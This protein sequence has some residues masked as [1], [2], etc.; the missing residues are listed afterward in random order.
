[1]ETVF[2]FASKFTQLK[3]EL[4]HSTVSEVMTRVVSYFQLQ[5]HMYHQTS[6]WHDSVVI[7]G[8]QSEVN[9]REF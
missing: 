3:A 8:N 7:P 2:S 1:M 5:Y 6:D 9:L 4:D